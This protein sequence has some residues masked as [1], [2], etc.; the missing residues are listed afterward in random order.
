LIN[1]AT[2]AR[3]AMPGGGK[4]VIELGN[5]ELDD[6]Y[7]KLHPPVVPGSYVMI[8][9][10]D[11]GCGMDAKTQAQIFDP[12][13]TTEELGKGT[14]L[15]L[16][17]VYGIVKQSGGYIW[18]YSEIAKGTVFRVYLPRVQQAKRAAMSQETDAPPARGCETILFA[19]DSESLR[20][21]A[22]EY[23]QSLGYEVIAADSG[24]QAIELAEK[25]SREIHL[26]LTDVVMPGMSGR[27]LADALAVRR[28][29]M[30]VLYSSGY[31]DDAVVR[32][33]VLQPGIAFIQKPYRPKALARKVREVLDSNK[34]DACTSST[35]QPELTTSGRTN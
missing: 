23:L 34:A 35:S 15:G 32:Q 3:D 25:S 10:S 26:L 33:G 28:P 19:E 29:G 13:F 6:E 24:A 22:E 7:K 21:I 17:T 8:A 30:K 20:E 4:L 31:T 12:F 16:A 18:V 27:E 1:L 14:G 9:V 11:T 2:N 5:A